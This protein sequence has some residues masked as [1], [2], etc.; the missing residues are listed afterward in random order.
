[1]RVRTA[2]AF[3]LA[4]VA[5]AENPKVAK[6]IDQGRAMRKEGAH[7]E[8]VAFFEQALEI[9]PT[10]VQAMNLAGETC[11][12]SAPVRLA[13]DHSRLLTFGDQFFNR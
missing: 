6:L 7:E 2:V 12:A 9:E 10:N 5:C 1:M 8:A 4:S 13:I 3:A 11:R